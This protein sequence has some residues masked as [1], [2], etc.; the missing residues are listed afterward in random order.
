[1]PN[2]A[3]LSAEDNATQDLVTLLLHGALQASHALDRLHGLASDPANTDPTAMDDVT[4]AIATM[5]RVR[6]ALISNADRL[7]GSPSRP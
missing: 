5:S 7:T 6:S 3:D 2:L 1:M 4:D